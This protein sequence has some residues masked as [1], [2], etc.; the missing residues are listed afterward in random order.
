MK[1]LLF[2]PSVLYRLGAK[3]MTLQFIWWWAE[4][5]ERKDPFFGSNKTYRSLRAFDRKR[6]DFRHCLCCDWS[7]LPGYQHDCDEAELAEL[8]GGIPRQVLSGE[9]AVEPVSKINT[10]DYPAYEDPIG[11]PDF[12]SPPKRQRRQSRHRGRF[13]ERV[14]RAFAWGPLVAL[15]NFRHSG[16]RFN[17]PI[18]DPN[19]GRW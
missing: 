3:V 4:K 17:S 13:F 10:R 11:T 6:R 12:D 9:I 1:V 19:K 7:V 8:L 16:V 14:S 5:I 2:I 18:Q 15:C